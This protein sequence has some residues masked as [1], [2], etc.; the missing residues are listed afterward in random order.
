MIN[1]LTNNKV[2]EYKEVIRD[3]A[4]KNG[5]EVCVMA[6]TPENLTRIFASVNYT[7]GRCIII[8]PSFIPSPGFFEELDYLWE[9]KIHVIVP[10]AYRA[11]FNPGETSPCRLDLLKEIAQD[12]IV[13][14]LMGQKKFIL[15]RSFHL[16]YLKNEQRD[17]I[18][19]IE[20]RC[21]GSTD[22]GISFRNTL[23]DIL[24]GITKNRSHTFL[25]SD[26]INRDRYAIKTTQ[27]RL[28]RAVIESLRIWLQ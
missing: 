4:R 15:P 11:V 27:K 25:G 9:Q 16:D 3:F 28:W 21:F 2:N 24:P 1:L 8:R 13:F 7:N 26:A 19:R 20:S 23:G 12:L 18:Y 22:K 17:C 14:Q 5:E 6:D 10:Q